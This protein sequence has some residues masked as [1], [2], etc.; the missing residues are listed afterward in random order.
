MGEVVV[1]FHTAIAILLIVYRGYDWRDNLACAIA[2]LAALTVAMFPCGREGS[3]SMV[4][5]QQL[6]PEW[7]EKVHYTAAAIFFLSLAF[8]SYFLF[9]IHK[10]KITKMK[11]QRDR[12]HKACGILIVIA[13]VVIYFIP[14]TW[15]DYSPMFWLEWFALAAFAVSWFVK[16]ETILKNSKS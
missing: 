6:Y 9:T 1:G 2:G 5:S 15:S 7:T 14:E 12:I 4:F 8:I 11:S 13:M 10:N 16:G 3:D